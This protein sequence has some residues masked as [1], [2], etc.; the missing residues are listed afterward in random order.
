MYQYSTSTKEDVDSTFKGVILGTITIRKL[1]VY[2]GGQ[3]QYNVLWWWIRWFHDAEKFRRECLEVEFYS[4]LTMTVSK[5]DEEGQRSRLETY[6]SEIFSCQALK[7][8][9]IRAQR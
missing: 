7:S 1:N 2:F 6:C 3:Y 5:H 9:T 8:C 4:R